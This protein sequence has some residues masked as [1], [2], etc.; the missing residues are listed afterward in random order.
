MNYKGCI[1]FVKMCGILA[2]FSPND[3]NCPSFHDRLLKLKARGPDETTIKRYVKPNLTTF[4]AGFV[5]NAISN[6]LNGSQPI[7][8]E[9]FVHL[10]NGEFYGEVELRKVLADYL[11][12]GLMW[13]HPV[14]SKNYLSMEESDSNLLKS[15]ASDSAME[16]PKSLDG[17]FAYC[18]YDK[19]NETLY[20][21]RD[22]VGVIPLY[23]VKEKDSIALG[24]E[25]KSYERIWFASEAKA[26]I[27]LGDI[28]VFMPNT[29]MSFKFDN[30]KIIERKETILPPYK[31][32]VEDERSYI[33]H[34][35]TLDPLLRTAVVKRNQYEVPWGVALSGGLDSN[36]VAFLKRQSEIDP[37]EP[38]E[39][40]DFPHRGGFHATHT[41]SIGLKSSND[42]KVAKE[43]ATSPMVQS[44]HHEIIIGI[45]EAL[46]CVEDVI[47]TIETYD[48]TT[49]RASVMN[50]LLAKYMKRFGIKVA[51]SGEG[52]DELF[53]GYLYFHNCPNKEEMEK[54]LKRKMENLH[55]YDCLRANKCFA[56]FGIEC[57]LPF[58]DRD[59]V[60]YVM[61]IDGVHNCR[62]LIQKG[63]KLKST[64]C[65]KASSTRRVNFLIW[66]SIV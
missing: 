25:E 10:H 47:W 58:L 15:M 66:T 28:H 31:E 8:T 9:N 6:V 51:Y 48:V 17:I 21:A 65:V 24:T 22:R 4:T 39:D 29:I 62:E 5:R 64:C 46:S 3:D 20:V 63:R 38:A 34:V 7:E 19:Q 16:F 42:L 52:A 50:Y 54:E 55:Y 49:V 23:Y 37:Y 2:C 43:Y 35:K 33:N 26:L 13:C 11:G 45:D 44:Y 60:D 12:Y 30:L 53:G 18:S 61:N 57:R 27:G 40:S 41:F 14:T 36:F 56:A 1:Y 59:F 32:V